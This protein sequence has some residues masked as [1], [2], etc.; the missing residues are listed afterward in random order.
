[1]F[2]VEFDRVMLPLRVEFDE[3][4]ASTSE[5]DTERRKWPMMAPWSAQ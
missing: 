1:M 5:G 2:A 3:L 4:L